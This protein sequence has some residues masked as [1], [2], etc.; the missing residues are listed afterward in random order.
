M[1]SIGSCCEKGILGYLIEYH[2]LQYCYYYFTKYNNVTKHNHQQQ[3]NWLHLKPCFTN[4]VTMYFCNVI[5]NA[6]CINLNKTQLINN[7][8]QSDEAHHFSTILDESETSRKHKLSSSRLRSDLHLA[9]SL[10]L[11]SPL[12]A[13]EEEKD[14]NPEQINIL[15]S[16]SGV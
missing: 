12:W 4:L 6:S 3:I 9:F 10:R 1:I 14:M 7:E 13:E 15:L 5:C 2:A 16:H 11:E 8:T